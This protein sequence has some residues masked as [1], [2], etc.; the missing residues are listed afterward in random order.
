M[1]VRIDSAT[2]IRSGVITSRTET[3]SRSRRRSCIATRFATRPWTSP[4][5][6]SSGSRRS[7]NARASGRAAAS[8]CVSRPT[9]L[10]SHQRAASGN[11]SS[12]S[13]S[14]VGRAVDDDHVPLA[15]LDVAL[16]AQQAEQ[17]VAAGRHGQLLGRDPLHAALDEHL[18]EPALHGRPVLLELDLRGD[19]LGPQVGRQLAGLVADGRLEH[20]GERVRRIGREHDRAQPGGGAAA[21]GGGGDGRLA[22]AALARVEDR[23]RGHR[24][25]RAYF[26][27]RLRFALSTSTGASTLAALPARSVASTRT[28]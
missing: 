16:E 15:R 18:P 10:P 8:S 4:M 20:V 7:R 9:S 14:P 12:R 25:P 22:D 2:T 17:L 11:E 13:V 23:A 3:A 24:R 19:L 6:S 21:G 28:R 1:K 26:A 5:T 27:P